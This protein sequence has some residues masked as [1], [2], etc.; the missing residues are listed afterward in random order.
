MTSVD[1]IGLIVTK[2]LKLGA[3]NYVKVHLTMWDQFNTCVGKDFSSR[4]S[5]DPCVVSAIS[6]T[7]SFSWLYVEPLNSTVPLQNAC[8]QLLFLRL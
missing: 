2:L 4:R 3:W 7:C 8:E 1:E 5:S 6:S